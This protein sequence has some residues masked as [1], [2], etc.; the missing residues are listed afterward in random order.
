MADAID[1]RAQS[2]PQAAGPRRLLSAIAAWLLDRSIGRRI[3][4][5]FIAIAMSTASLGL[6]GYYL[7]SSAGALIVETYDRPLMAINFARASSLDFALMDKA[8]L[9]LRQAP[10]A[11]RPAIAAQ[12]DDLADT[13]FAD[14]QVARERSLG[15][16]QRALIDEI[17]AEVRA[18]EA[19][20]RDPAESVAALDAKAAHI[21]E[22]FDLL[23]ELTAGA[24][25][26]ERRKAIWAI[27]EF[28]YL[29]LGAAALALLL[30]G[31][32]ALI[33]SRRIV[34]PLS[35]AASVANRIAGGELQTAIPAGEADETGTLLRSMAVMQDNIHR[36]MER[37]KAQKESAQG[38]LADAI[39]GAREGMALVDADGR[40]AGVNG[41]AIALFGLAAGASIA[42][43]QGASRTT[44][45]HLLTS[46]HAQGEFD[47]PDGSW[48]HYS[49]NPTHDGGMFFF[50][51]DLSSI[52]EREDRLREARREAEAASAA[53]S[54]FLAA[55]SHELRTPLNAV[56]GFSEIVRDARLGPHKFPQYGDYAGQVV[57]SG[58]QLLSIINAVL[59]LTKAQAGS[60]DLRP[61]EID[62]GLLLEDGVEHHARTA[63]G[64]GIRLELVLDDPD[65]VAF[66]DPGRV[67]QALDQ[68]LANAVRFSPDGGTVRVQAGHVDSGL[69]EVAISDSG[70]G[71]TGD[72]VATALAAFGQVDGR[73][74][75]RYEG[76]GLGLPLA[77][78]LMECQGGRLAVDSR[79]G[80]GTTV[81]LSI[82]AE[83]A[84]RT[85][86]A[87]T[88]AA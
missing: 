31:T 49:R 62:L 8:A 41:H 52:R 20:R 61:D 47:G 22:R 34:A 11:E 9:R 40:V 63:R 77:R 14:L 30:A 70:P 17:V 76:V 18:W 58:Q 66:A 51:T 44:L 75:R 28:E 60:L 38:R 68:V 12:I 53:K 32:I 83:D 72:E 33:L 65:A 71:M 23:T 84:S 24:S 35:A 59:D 6:Y 67:R 19:L 36:M 25:F 45:D 26:V 80:Q 42:D 46:P 29:S 16:D 85:A 82:P 86:Q 74:D 69:I 64:R 4:L 88:R 10:E 78:A 54:Q 37:E 73:L 15:E 39:E 21:I 87:A 43:A 2:A 79:P 13:A 57:D 55:M 56:I 1:R 81:R 7:L 3:F 50:F 27:R 48:I 5:A